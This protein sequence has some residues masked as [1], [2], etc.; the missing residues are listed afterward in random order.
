MVFYLPQSHASLS[1]NFFC[2]SCKS[3]LQAPSGLCFVS[4]FAFYSS[5]FNSYLWIYVIVKSERKF[6]RNHHYMPIYQIYCSYWCNTVYSVT[7]SEETIVRCSTKYLF[8]KY[9]RKIR[10]VEF[11][12]ILQGA[13]FFQGFP[14][15]NGQFFKTSFADIFRKMHFLLC[16]SIYRVQ[17]TPSGKCT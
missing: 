4:K 3:V 16:D 9:G 13:V 10:K 6:Y 15:V 8:L 7:F 12:K 5:K 11:L 14:R 1:D 17:E 2:N